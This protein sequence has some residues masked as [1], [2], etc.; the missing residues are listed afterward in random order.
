[1][2][3]TFSF[4]SISILLLVCFSS[5]FII[6]ECS[7][8]QIQYPSTIVHQT[9]IDSQP[10]NNKLTSSLPKITSSTNVNNIYI[11]QPLSRKI[12]ALYRARNC[13]L[14]G[15]KPNRQAR[16]VSFSHK[17][18]KTVQHVNLQVKHYVSALLKRIIKLRISARGIKTVENVYDGDIDRAASKFG[19]D[20]K[21]F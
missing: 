9:S 8:F 11:T 4:L 17:R 6:E 10:S 20:L 13:D 19:V 5:L 2:A 12:T 21:K 14:L 18:T 3:T 1:M 16:T 15:S 7:S